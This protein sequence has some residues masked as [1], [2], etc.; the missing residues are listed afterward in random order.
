MSGLALE[1]SFYSLKKMDDLFR[2]EQKISGKKFAILIFNKFLWPEKP[3]GVVFALF[4][5]L[6]DVVA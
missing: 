4:F 2:R 6:R 3:V 5:S 1:I